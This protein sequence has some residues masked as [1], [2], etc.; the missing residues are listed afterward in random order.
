[1]YEEIALQIEN[2][3]MQLLFFKKFLRH[4]NVYIFTVNKLHLDVSVLP[5]SL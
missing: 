3:N 2:N 1:M 4:N 5:I